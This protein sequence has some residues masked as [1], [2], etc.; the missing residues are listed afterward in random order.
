[1]AQALT[2]ACRHGG[3]APDPPSDILRSASQ[4][5]GVAFTSLKL[6]L[7][8]VVAVAVG[9][10]ALPTLSLAANPIVTENQQPGTGQWQI[11]NAG[12][13]LADDSSNQIRCSPPAARHGPAASR[14]R[15]I[16]MPA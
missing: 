16:R 8:L 1:M 9:F 2:G 15:A 5:Q 10:G 13:Q 3:I 11:P 7:V 4:A 12:F 6:C 14:G